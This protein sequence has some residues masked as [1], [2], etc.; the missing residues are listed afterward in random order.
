MR[1]K[2]NRWQGIVIKSKCPHGVVVGTVAEKIVIHGID[3]SLSKVE[4]YKTLGCFYISFGEGIVF[5]L[6]LIYTF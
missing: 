6:T 4:T 5:S 3:L 1:V 2:L